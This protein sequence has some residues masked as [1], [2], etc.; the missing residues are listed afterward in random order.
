MVKNLSANAGDLG[1]I[2][3]SSV[4]GISQARKLEW[5]IIDSPGDLPKPGIEHTSPDC[6]VDS[7]PMSNMESST[8]KQL[9]NIKNAL[10]G[11]LIIGLKSTFLN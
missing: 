6:Q 8:N 9:I 2:P 10:F 5:V 4:H 11:L 7:L 1:S 3:G